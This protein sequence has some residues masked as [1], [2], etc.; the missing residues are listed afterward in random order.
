M[1]IRA[2]TLGAKAWAMAARPRDQ[3][4]E[5]VEV[6]PAALAEQA[7]AEPAYGCAGKG[8]GGEQRALEA[9]ELGVAEVG[10]N[11]RQHQADRGE[12]VAVAE[13]A[14]APLHVRARLASGRP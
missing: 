1:A 8:R 4:V 3:D 10:E 5:P 11:F 7:E 9:S 6:L 14:Q 2:T 12:V 13:D